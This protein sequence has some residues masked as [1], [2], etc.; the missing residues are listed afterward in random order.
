MTQKRRRRRWKNRPTKG[1]TAGRNAN[2]K[3]A[4]K[5]SVF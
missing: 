3:T 4:L 1:K 5:A 2:K